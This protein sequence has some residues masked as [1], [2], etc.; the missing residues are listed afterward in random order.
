MIRERRGRELSRQLVEM[1]RERRG[2]ELS[3]Q[4]VEIIGEWRGNYLR[5][6]CLEASWAGAHK[7]EWEGEFIRLLR[8]YF[9][10]WDWPWVGR[11]SGLKADRR[12]EWAWVR[13][14]RGRS[15][16]V[17]ISIAPAHKIR[18]QAEVQQGKRCEEG[19]GG[20]EKSTCLFLFPV[21]PPPPSLPS[22]RTK[23]AWDKR[24][25]P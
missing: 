5:R 3:R 12:G 13:V 23:F 10:C 15:G 2:R 14:T 25:R 21:C 9:L 7:Q 19:R 18:S 16:M 20:M 17:S 4:L 1:I 6:T 11:K 22:F 8:F 24:E